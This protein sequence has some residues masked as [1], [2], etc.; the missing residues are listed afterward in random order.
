MVVNI[1]A[2]NVIGSRLK[3]QAR[4]HATLARIKL[5]V[6]SLASLL[7]RAEVVVL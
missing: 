4:A 5:L 6:L 3:Q 1:A 2:L 7:E